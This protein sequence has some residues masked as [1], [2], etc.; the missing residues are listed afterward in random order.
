MKQTIL[1][2]YE[3]LEEYFKQFFDDNALFKS[4]EL[5]NFND[6]YVIYCSIYILAAIFLFIIC[7]LTNF[8]RVR[9][10]EVIY[11]ATKSD[12]SSKKKS[13]KKSQ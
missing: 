11:V 1:D 4:F 9:P 2:Y 13:E 10:T 3:R 6:D 8:Y 12:T 7:S 5:Y